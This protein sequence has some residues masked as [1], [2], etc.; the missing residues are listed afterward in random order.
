MR[1]VQAGL[2]AFF[3]LVEIDV[4]KKLEDRRSLIGQKPLE[5]TDVFETAPP[6]RF[7][8]KF[9]HPDNKNILVMAPVKND[10]LPFPGCVFVNAPEI[11]M[12][13]LLLGR[14]LKT[15][16]FHSLR[17]D[18]IKNMPDRTVFSTRVHSLKDDED[19]VLIFG[20]E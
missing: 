17:I 20:I 7:G 3:L 1:F 18:S 19:F 9:M 4:K 2:K 13:Q 15:G 11:V 10:D 16:D 12:S 5:V 8:N 14:D 6:D